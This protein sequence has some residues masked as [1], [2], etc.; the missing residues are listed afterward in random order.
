MREQDLEPALF[1]PLVCR[2][3]GPQ[4]ANQLLFVGIRSSRNRGVPEDDC[5][6]IV[7]TAVFSGVI[8]RLLDFDREHAA[9]GDHSLKQGIVIFQEEFEELLLMSPLSL[10]VILHRV[11]LVCSALRWRSLCTR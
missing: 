5:Y 11:R 4:L 6:P 3:V 7:P 2:L 8:G 10:V 1:F 9:A